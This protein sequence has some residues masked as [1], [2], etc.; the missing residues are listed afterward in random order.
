MASQRNR[1]NQAQLFPDICPDRAANEISAA[2][3]LNPRQ[4]AAVEHGDGP[5][6]VVAG[7]GTGKTR[8]ITERIR[9]LLQSNPDLPGDSIVG[10]TFTDKAAAEMKA[11]VRRSAGERAEDVFLGTFHAFCTRML[12]EHDP[13]LQ[14]IEEVDH[15]ILL[16]RNLRLLGLQR[17]RMLAEPGKFLSDF[18]RFF[19]RCQDELVTPDD[20]EKYVAE[21][22]AALDRERTALQPDEIALREEEIGRQI[23]IARAYRASDT[24][25]RESKRITFGMQ[26]MDAVKMLRAN[27]A[28]LRK[29]R[30]RF[31]YILVDEFQDTN[32]AQLEL[33]WLLAGD[34]AQAG[35][36]RNIL[37]V[38]DD[39]QAIY[40]FR[41]ASFASFTLFLEKFAG[42]RKGDIA[43][44]ADFVLPLLDNY[45][46]TARI[47]TVAGQV[48]EY[49]ERS[50]LVPPNKLLPHRPSGD[51][52]RIVE[53]GS[54][55]EEALWIA[56]EIER[57]HNAAPAAAP[58]NSFAALYRIHAHRDELVS[59]L[60]ERGIPFV[61]RNLSIFNEPLVMDVMAYL[62][63][64]A[65]PSN[66]IACAR[67]LSA[68][69]WRFEAE[70]LV[71]LAEQ[72]AKS[73]KSL[74]EQLQAPQPELPFAE[75]IAAERAALISAVNRLRQRAKT[76]IVSEI[77]DE[78][79][80]WLQIG[81]VTPAAERRYIDRLARF[82]REWEPKSATKKLPEFMEYL[83]YFEQAGGKIEMEQDGGDAVQL[84]TVHAAKGLEF[85]HVFV[86]RLTHKAFPA[87]ERKSVLEF[88]PALMKE[89][90][91]KHPS[92]YHIEEERRLFY[93]ALT[94]AKD[95][96][97][98]TTV[99]NAR[100]KPSPFLD[101][102]LSAPQLA[103]EHVLQLSPKPLSP[104]QAAPAEPR[105]E[106][107]R[108]AASSAK[109]R[110]A[111][112]LFPEG[113]QPPRVYSRIADWA[114]QYRPPV[115]DPLRLST[116]AIE[117]YIACPQKHLFSNRWGIRGGPA[118]SMTFGRAMHA[119][120]QEFLGAVKKG[121][122]LP[123]FEEV[124][125][126]FRRE[127]S[128]AGF[129]DDYQEECYLRDGIEQLRAFHQSCLAG[130]P[131]ILDQ[132]KVFTLELSNNVQ[133]TG[134]IDQLNVLPSTDQPLDESVPIH[135]RD[136]E[137]IDYKT[138]RPKSEENARKDLQLGIYALAAK[139]ALGLN[140]VRL[141][142]HNLQGNNQVVSARDEKQLAQVINTIQETA[143]NIRA[144]RF[145]A[146][147][148]FQCRNCEYWMLCPAQEAGRGTLE[149]L[150]PPAQAG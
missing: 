3:P 104:Q 52:V 63:L 149:E 35:H 77:F 68:P 80:E 2:L 54:A 146:R 127:W 13:G 118:A 10:L 129:E 1:S 139:E 92:E 98:L 107:A 21:M 46:S 132:E 61:I 56:A 64:V 28:V 131:E 141:V 12:L 148:G 23:E 76:L 117:S 142:Y 53:F 24:L 134:R 116:S 115:F 66:D 89:E 97:T 65:R 43:V 101:D 11:R 40:R 39:A 111:A 140:P 70:D 100:A 112:P 60:E 55:A 30:E 44:A 126:I 6:L 143:A 69:A 20:Y 72:A 108:V 58:W 95:R 137:I 25:L 50:P 4:R 90:L 57:L 106:N 41:G 85:D 36:Q 87:P 124:E 31:R 26:L 37:A 119:A 109:R 29:L 15:W 91:P 49:L 42:V 19:S 99:V 38:G 51:K 150:E 18:V 84:M 22:A 74:W 93:V 102:I 122:P 138:G 62:H 8:V 75:N 9:H 147:P 17:Y 136:V 48:S 113:S 27:P 81:A 78:L 79:A 96:L 128:S 14:P 123:P 144:D 94:R 82:V 114:L 16:R 83:D 130:L 34:S 145:P 133:V 73:R 121:R 59:A 33:L 32:V 105:P 120:I 45:R 71:R 125:T 5:L 135:R 86:I 88:P 67:V 110:P 7:A 47:V 103:R